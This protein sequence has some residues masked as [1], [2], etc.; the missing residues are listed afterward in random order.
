MSPANRFFIATMAISLLLCLSAPAFADVELYKQPPTLS[1]IFY[2]SQNDVGG[3]GNFATAYDN[4]QIYQLKPYY[5]DDVEW[6][7]GYWNG[8][9]NAITG[10]TVS[11]YADA[12]LAPGGL[13]WSQHF[14]V[15]YPGYMESCNL[16]NGVCAYDIDN[17][18]GG[19]KLMP[20]TT[21]WLSVVPDLTFPPQWGWGMGVLG[22]NVAYQDFFGN[23][24]QL[25]T[26]FALNVQGVIP[27][28]STLILLGT[29]ILGLAGIL[30][31]KINL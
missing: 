12:G 6:F 10:W 8:P 5:L 4:F 15:A 28:P 1:G 2:A 27:E 21:Y 23:R 22:D 20:N 3:F 18:M 14:S 24:T 17:I 30:R 7:G 31:R 9:G 29:G 19:Y 11:L 16:P 25:G 13:L 26:D